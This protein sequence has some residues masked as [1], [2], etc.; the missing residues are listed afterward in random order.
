MKLYSAFSRSE[1]WDF[2][3]FSPFFALISSEAPVS[4]S[5][6]AFWGASGLSV[7][8][9]LVSF[10]R[11][12]DLDVSGLVSGLF[13][14]SSSIELIT[15]SSLL[16]F[17]LI[18]C[19]ENWPA[20][21]SRDRFIY[22]GVFFVY[23]IGMSNKE[24]AKQIADNA[25]AFHAKLEKEPNGRYRSWEHCYTIFHK[26][27]G[28]KP[29][30]SDK[31]LLCLNL[32]FY[33]ASWGMYRGSSFLLQQDYKVH[34]KVVDII[35]DKKY[36]KL[37][38]ADCKDI[39]LD[40]LIEVSEKIRSEYD[41]IRKKVNKVLG[42]V[43]KGK[44]SDTLVTKVLMGTFGCAPAYDRYFISGVRSKEVATQNFNKESMAKLVD[45]YKE[46]SKTFDNAL[47][48]MKV[49]G[50]N[51]PQMKLLDMGFWQIGFVADGGDENKAL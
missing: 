43:V 20:A 5:I 18:L 16:I 11:F 24:L 17:Y 9:W 49:N 22:E 36:A 27:K 50:L 1:Y 3:L 6:F 35:L 44:V 21:H 42:K 31:D 29:G 23:L 38:G 32:A 2:G 47:S 37:F 14:G 48:S 41:D 34:G 39:D 15:S 30:K 10:A 28:K 25:K 8:F 13:L 26:F 33:L 46:N 51:Y 7:A 4:T 45:F 40:L 12:S 19:V